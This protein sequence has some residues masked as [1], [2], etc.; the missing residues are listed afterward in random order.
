[1]RYFIVDDDSAVR[2]MLE[3]IIEDTD[4]GE[5]IGEAESGLAVTEN[6]LAVG[7]VDVLVID[8]LMPGRD[9]IETIKAI[10]SHFTGKIVM[11]SQVE[12]KDLI[13]EAYSLGVEYYVSKPLNR[14]EIVNILQKVN[15]NL[16]LERSVQDIKKSLNFLTSVESTVNKKPYNDKSIS[17]TGTFLLSELGVLG[18]AGTK[19]LL[20][21]LEYLYHLESQLGSAYSFPPLKEILQNIALQ[22]IGNADHSDYSKEMKAAEQRIRRAI[23]QALVHIASLGLT[24]Y[25]NPTFERYASKFFEFDQVRKKMSELKSNSDSGIS[26]IRINTKKFV[27]VLYWEAKQLLA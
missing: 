2:A 3:E 15:N 16:L 19:D 1:M 6:S 5:I 27:Q 23:Y 4:L 20:H 17:N 25:S 10:Q 8:L 18:E 12:S 11:L 26:N 24:D 13:G 14:V 22:K 9:G 21:I 7:K